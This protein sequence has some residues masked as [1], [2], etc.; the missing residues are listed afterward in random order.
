M[1]HSSNAS[2]RVRLFVIEPEFIFVIRGTPGFSS[3]R[4]RGVGERL[5]LCVVS[6]MGKKDWFHGKP[7]VGA[8]T[9]W[10][11]WLARYEIARD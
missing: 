7:G 5:P 2:T 1:D 10:N 4:G 11:R 9:L 3:G 8:A 6:G